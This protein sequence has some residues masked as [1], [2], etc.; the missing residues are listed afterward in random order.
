MGISIQGNIIM[1]ILN[2]LASLNEE[3]VTSG[4]MVDRYSKKDTPFELFKN[5]SSSEIKDSYS[6]D[7]FLRW[8]IVGDDLYVWTSDILH[9][10]MIKKLRSNGT[11]SDT[12]TW[13][14]WGVYNKNEPKKVMVDYPTKPEEIKPFLKRFPNVEHISV[15][16]GKISIPI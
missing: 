3:W 11:V 6:D 4:N 8:A 12:S 14:Y 2:E 13:D 5:P 10:W 9:Q 7:E 16:G 1:S 15:A